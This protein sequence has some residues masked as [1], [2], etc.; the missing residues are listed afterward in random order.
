[1]TSSDTLA[2]PSGHP[3][4][5]QARFSPRK[6]RQISQGV[7]YA[8][9]VA[10]VFALVVVADWERIQ[11]GFFDGT[12]A[13]AMLPELFTVALRNT[14]IYTICGYIFGFIL[15]LVVAM[16]RLSSAAPNRLVALVFIEIFRGV[17][18]LL[19]F[20]I[21][22][23]GL[24]TA[25]PEFSLPF[26]I[27]GTATL[28]LGLVAA[29]YLAETFRAGIQAVPKGQMEAA[30]SLGMSYTR[31]MI[32]IVI[33]QAI[34]IVIPPLT[35]ELILLFKDSSL[36]FVLGVTASTVELT[37]FGRDVSM[38]FATSTPLLLAGVSYLAITVP[39]GYAVRTLEARQA[40]ERR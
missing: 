40:R 23:F 33:P 21:I 16:M 19:V 29:A 39:L 27:Y 3:L 15:G 14:V 28:S 7:Q 10:V 8:A 36:I 22:G 31:A 4:P 9:F 24:P 35:N 5:G 17:P 20:V 1:M 26:G 32:T 18:A 25:F 37:K 2:E 11:Q 34:R 13:A 38:E 6:R 30:R 12:S